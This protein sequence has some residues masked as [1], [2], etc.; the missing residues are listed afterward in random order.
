MDKKVSVIIPSF[1]GRD[2]IGNVLKSLERQIYSNFEVIVVIDGSTDGTYNY[3]ENREWNLN[4]LNFFQQKNMGRSGAKNAGAKLAKSD[5]LIFFD[6]DIIFSDEYLVGKYVSLLE[7]EEYSVV[8]GG[9]EPIFSGES[10]EFELYCQYLNNKWCKAISRGILKSPYITANNFGINRFFFQE[11][12]GFDDRL[13]DAEDFDL[14]VKI[15]E[16]GFPIFFDSH[17]M[18][19]HQLNGSFSNLIKR[20]REYKKANEHLLIINPVA[21]NYRRHLTYSIGKKTF[22]WF[23]LLPFLPSSIDNFRLRFLPAK[24]KFK[25]YDWILEANILFS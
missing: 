6:D 16:A 15:F 9:L 7:K 19:H 10:S 20:Q 2:K 3:L 22:L 5:Y 21:G 13:Q 23:F 11:M 24:L 18:V 14:A 12:G 17:L 25:V 1:N 4:S 8:V